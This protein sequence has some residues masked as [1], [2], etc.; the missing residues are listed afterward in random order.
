MKDD[1]IEKAKRAAE[2]LENLRSRCETSDWCVSANFEVKTPWCAMLTV[3]DNRGAPPVAKDMLP[4]D[5]TF[6]AGAFHHVS[7][8]V[9]F[10]EICSAIPGLEGVIA[11]THAVVPVEPTEAMLEAAIY[12][13]RPERP[14]VGEVLSA[15][16]RAMIDASK[17]K[18]AD[19][20]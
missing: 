19:H 15:E 11:G 13:D 20:G 3:R 4:H 1:L 18:D 7:A 10:V 14:T 9:E 12:A 6:C 17:A 5:A 2:A 8:L 16:Y